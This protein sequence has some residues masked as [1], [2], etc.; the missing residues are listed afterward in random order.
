[1]KES[2]YVMNIISCWVTLDYLEGAKTRKYFI[3]S[4]G[5]K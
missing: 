1:M 3:D 2:Y 4:C 5:T